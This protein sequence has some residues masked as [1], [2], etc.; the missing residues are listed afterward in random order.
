MLADQILL[1]YAEQK[2][3]DWT[4]ANPPCVDMI[5]GTRFKSKNS[6]PGDDGIPYFAWDILDEFGIVMGPCSC[7][8]GT[9]GDEEWH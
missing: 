7:R 4:L 2:Y 5:R 1:P 9:D 6:A 8:K 3:W